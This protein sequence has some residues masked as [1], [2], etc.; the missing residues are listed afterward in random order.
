MPDVTSEPGKRGRSK[1]LIREI[2]PYVKPFIM[3]GLNISRVFI[4][5]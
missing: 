1:A 2:V 3:K 4:Y 5:C